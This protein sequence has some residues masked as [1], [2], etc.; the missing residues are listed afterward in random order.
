MAIVTISRIQHRRGVYENLP[1]LSAAELGWAA[2][3]RR[4]FIGNGPLSE[5]APIIGNTEIL[6]EYSDILG[7]ADAYT[8]KNAVA[9]YTPSTGIDAN[10]PTVRTLQ[11][12][13]DDF[14]S[15][16]DFGALGDGAT[17]DTVAINRALFELYCREDF[18][19]AKKALYFPAGQYIISGEL[20]VP[21]HA[22]LIGEGP[23][24]TVIEQ[25]ADIGD[26]SVI[27][28]TADDLQQIEGSLGSNG[29]NLPTDI[30]ISAMGLLANLDG[31]HV[32]KCKRITLERIRFVGV[33]NLPTS[34]N[35]V[36]TGEPGVG[37]Y[38][39]GSEASPTE[40]VNIID[41][42][43]SKHNVGIWQNVADEVIEN[44]NIS[45]ATFDNLYQGIL[46]GVTGGA[47]KN[48]VVTN[49][50]FDNI[51]SRAVNV[52]NVQAF[53]SSF[54]YYVDVGNGYAGAGS[55]IAEV[56]NFGNLTSNSTSMGDL[57][58]RTD[59]DNATVNT[60]VMN[61]NNSFYNYSKKLNLGYMA[62]NNGREITLT[63]AATDANT[64]ITFD[65][66]IVNHAVITYTIN[67]VNDNRSGTLNISFS[68]GSYSIDDDSTETGDV[69][70]T[71]DILLSSG[72]VSVTYTTSSIG[73][74]AT[75]YYSIAQLTN[76][77]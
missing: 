46:I 26:A 69:G 3:Q 20:K 41:C 76:V 19:G 59:A 16:R 23:Y 13:F 30:K 10:S 5:G 71:F 70:V 74:D 24:S 1:Q 7:A 51:Y 60:I 6:T 33:E 43:F 73:D 63:D 48:V 42:Y 72:T 47:A 58:N 15:V 67:R 2:D 45:S 4:L 9:G 44:I 77:V 31:I 14:V 29:A 39:S 75:F 37:I 40:D 55:P 12:K 61:E 54:N 25:T 50:V 65:S 52:N 68:S 18:A 56:I 28:H 64:N 27:F 21:P 49:T 36:D 17:D 62:I 8:Y 57:F 38:L 35:N 32:S 22:T 66:S 11:E 53:I 34:I